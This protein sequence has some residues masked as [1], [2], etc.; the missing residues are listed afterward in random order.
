LQDADKKG[1]SRIGEE[2]KQLAQKAKENSLKPEDFEVRI[3]VLCSLLLMD[4]L[5]PHGIG[6]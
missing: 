6:C 5:L 1:L 2:V 3:V 4:G